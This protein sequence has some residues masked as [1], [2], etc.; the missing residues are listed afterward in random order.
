M[1][2][3]RYTGIHKNWYLT[4][5]V[6]GNPIDRTIFATQALA[7]GNPANVVDRAG[8][9]LAA[10][11]DTEWANLTTIFAAFRSGRSA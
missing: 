4:A 10:A 1:L 2:D 9:G 5:R 3:A 11:L 8:G 7:K 6:S